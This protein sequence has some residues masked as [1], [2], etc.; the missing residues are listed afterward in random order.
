MK[1]LKSKYRQGDPKNPWKIHQCQCEREYFDYPK[2]CEGCEAREIC[3]TEELRPFFINVTNSML[4]FADTYETAKHYAN[5]GHG[6]LLDRE[7][8]EG[9]PVQLTV[10]DRQVSFRP[11]VRD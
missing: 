8:V 5:R 11:D 1:T 4:V 3:G 10:K 9:M 6:W 2:D 7:S